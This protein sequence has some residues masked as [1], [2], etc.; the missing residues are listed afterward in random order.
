MHG[1]SLVSILENV[2]VKP[3]KNPKEK[4]AKVTEYLIFYFVTKSN[5]IVID[6]LLYLMAIQITLGASKQSREVVKMT[7][8]E[9]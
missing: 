7:L 3:E 1:V 6:S 5:S 4:R 2:S 9:N 8:G